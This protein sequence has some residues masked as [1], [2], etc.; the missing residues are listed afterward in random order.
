MTYETF[1]IRISISCI[2]SFFIG[3]ERQWRRRAIGLRTNVLVSIGAFLFVTFSIQINASD[4]TR[5]AAQV[6]SGIGFLGA[7]IILKDGSNVKGLNTAATLWCN[8]A[9]GTLCAAG[10][11]IE[12]TIGTILILFANII[13]RFITQKL[14]MIQTKNKKYDN[15]RLKVTCEEEKEIVIRTLISQSIN[16]EHMILTNMESSELEDAK[17]RIYATFRVSSDKT[18]LIEKLINRIVMEPGITSSGWKKIDSPKNEELDDD[19]L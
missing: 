17:T 13:L 3:L 2:L 16:K 1:L 7:G 6:V 11:L 15:Y 9:I 14:N 5:I 4:M 12:A 10:L 8:A 18:N 19:E